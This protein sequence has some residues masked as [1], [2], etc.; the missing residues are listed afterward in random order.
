VPTSVGCQ[1]AAQFRQRA[2]DDRR[3]G[4]RLKSDQ[5]KVS[6]ASRANFFA[7][8]AIVAE[9]K[10]KVTLAEADEAVR[11]ALDTAR[12]A[13]GARSF[14]DVVYLWG[15]ADFKATEAASLLIRQLTASSSK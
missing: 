3:D 13:E 6:T 10:C 7:S 14:Y 8:L 12:K 11:A 2:N 5:G 4:A 1:D 9:L 15:D